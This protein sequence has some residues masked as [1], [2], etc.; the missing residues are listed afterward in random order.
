MQ[1]TLGHKALGTSRV[2]CE[3]W[4][5]YGWIMLIWWSWNVGDT[6]EETLHIHCS[7]LLGHTALWVSWFLPRRWFWKAV[8]QWHTGEETL[9]VP[10]SG[11]LGYKALQVFTVLLIRWSWND[12][13]LGGDTGMELCTFIVQV[14]WDTQSSHQYRYTQKMVLKWLAT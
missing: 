1:V 3:R 4:S 9:H 10:W 8:Y 12:R 14:S 11:L 13:T 7:C 2:Q 6:R 5:W